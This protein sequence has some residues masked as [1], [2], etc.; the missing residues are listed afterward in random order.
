MFSA[1]ICGVHMHIVAAS[2]ALTAATGSAGG[3]YTL[4]VFSSNHRLKLQAC[5]TCEREL[6]V[7]DFTFL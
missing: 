7:C 2:Y 3:S 4:T 1:G 6:G 5:V